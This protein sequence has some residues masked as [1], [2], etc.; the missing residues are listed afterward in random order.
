M[1]DLDWLDYLDEQNECNPFTI[2]ELP[3]DVRFRYS[4]LADAA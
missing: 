4:E 3:P 2:D 1:S